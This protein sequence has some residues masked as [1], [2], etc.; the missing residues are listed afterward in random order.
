MSDLKAGDIHTQINI[1]R[2]DALNTRRGKRDACRTSANKT[3]AGGVQKQE[4]KE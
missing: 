2:P 1:F 4:H 3:I